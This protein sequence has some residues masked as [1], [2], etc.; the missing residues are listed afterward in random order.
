MRAA[1]RVAAPAKGRSKDV[2]VAEIMDL[3]ECPQFDRDVRR[4][5]ER[6]V[7]RLIDDLS[8]TRTSL[9]GVRRDNEDHLSDLRG[10][11]VKLKKKVVGLPEHL[12]AAVFA[13]ERFDSLY[14]LHGSTA[15]FNP[16]TR[17]YL[18][19]S[20]LRRERLTLISE[21]DRIRERCDELARRGLGK[22]GGVKHLQRHAAFASRGLLESVASFTGT[23]LSLSCAKDSKYCRV[24]SLFFEAGGGEYGK[25]L[26]RSCEA[27]ASDPSGP[28][29]TQ[30]G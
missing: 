30:N 2:I 13:S 27:V 9:T 11:S 14:P 7:R 17:D 10:L 20:Q 4:Q 3:V 28:F 23:N 21:L 15:E 19:Q 8:A 5:I 12:A 24:A 26:V 1:A 25:D 18:K 16:S 29:S 6:V 22:H